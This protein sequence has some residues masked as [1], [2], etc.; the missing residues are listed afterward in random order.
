MALRIWTGDPLDFAAL[1]FFAISLFIVLRYHHLLKGAVAD[2]AP[3]TVLG[4]FLAT[5]FSASLVL[6]NVVLEKNVAVMVT[7]CITIVR[8]S[9]L[10]TAGIILFKLAGFSNPIRL[11]TEGISSLKRMPWWMGL[12][13]HCGKHLI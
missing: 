8:H 13:G 9:I 5:G 4:I 1:L 10:A 6:R 12:V 7:N 2:V 11:S 3:F